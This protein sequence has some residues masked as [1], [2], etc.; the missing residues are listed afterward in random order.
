MG[1]GTH[2]WSY[3]PVFSRYS[4]MA[5][6]CYLKHLKFDNRALAKLPVDKSHRLNQ[7]RV[8]NACF[9][10]VELSEVEN[11]K[12]VAFSSGALGLLNIK[13]PTEAGDQKVFSEELANYFSGN[14]ELE[15]SETYAHCYCG[16]QFG[17]FSGQLGDGAAI[18]LGQVNNEK[19]EGWEL[20]LK[21]AGKTPFSRSADGRKV[22]RSSIREFLCSEAMHYL[23]VPTTRAA[24]VITSDT[25][26]VRDIFYDGNAAL[27]DCAVVLRLSPTF[28]RFGS[29]EIFKPT[30][31]QTGRD[32]P[33]KGNTELLHTM[34]NFTISSYYPDIDSEFDDQVEKYAQFYKE[35]CLRT[36]DLVAKWQCVGFCHGVLNTDNM[37][38][39]GL[40]LDY[41]PFGFMDSFD[42]DFICNASDENGRYTYAKQ[43][44]I[45]KWNLLKFAEAIQEALP[46]RQ[47]TKILE[48]V[49]ESRFEASYSAGMRGKLGLF[50]VQSEDKQL[51]ENLFKTMQK[52]RSDFTNTFRALHHL[53]KDEESLKAV[54][55][56]L[57]ECSP[58]L[59]DVKAILKP[60]FDMEQIEHFRILAQQHPAFATLTGNMGKMMSR[61]MEKR[62]QLDQLKETGSEGWSRSNRDQWM[63]W[64]DG[65][66]ERIKRDDDG[67]SGEQ[68]S[69][70]V[71]QRSQM[72]SEN[73]PKYVLR[74]YIAH[75][76]I[77]EAENGNFA[78]VRNV[79]KRLENPY[80]GGDVE[81]IPVKSNKDV[82]YD[83]IPSKKMCG[84][85]VS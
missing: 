1:M 11:P 48:E 53:G 40:T 82:S 71:E 7:R 18:Y 9:S 39:V 2:V 74:N 68:I 49:Y 19:N 63:K 70:R 37:S 22:L 50:T 67:L 24:S 56:K 33:S 57:V 36:A 61:E 15:G 20:Q 8:E 58:S 66:G 64:L 85:K 60:A 80:G 72:M 75:N 34:L 3:L 65:Y 4:T 14:E 38:V 41:G 25:K 62:E 69:D 43:P 29:F 10:L 13:T 17:Y 44:E 35:I 45:C 78:E 52:T 27:E 76:A 21:G 54:L 32:G 55:A 28:L 12:V 47:S 46:L 77:K 51:F 59:E 23:G 42:P 73:N 79:L 16:H 84:L 5:A 6:A 26:V 31:S 81:A 30:D 83:T